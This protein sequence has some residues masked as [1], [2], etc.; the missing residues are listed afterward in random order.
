MTN[1]DRPRIAPTLTPPVATDPVDVLLAPEPR[2]PPGPPA[3][4]AKRRRFRPLRWLFVLFLIAM[5]AP[6]AIVLP[7]RWYPPPTSAFMLRSEVQPV[8]YEWVDASR[9]PETLRLAAIGAEDQKFWDHFGFDLVAIAEAL[10]HNEKNKRK[11]GAS[12]ITQQVAKNLFMWPSRSYLRKGLEA[13]FTLLIELCWPKERILE[14]YLNIAEFGPGVYGAQAAAREFFDK[15]AAD[16]TPVESARLVAVLP[17]PRKW[18]AKH[19][20]P[21]VQARVDWILAHIGYGPPAEPEQA[22][23]LEPETGPELILEPAIEGEAPVEAPADQPAPPP[24]TEAPADDA[25]PAA[26]TAEPP[27]A[28]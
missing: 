12:T 4:P 13:T 15:D 5:L 11:R 23:E 25:A 21:Y 2:E 22:L 1:R 20:G 10:E 3:P 27:P 18:S 8:K 7:L 16:L 9:I 28:P 26:D 19:P 14:V 6:P 17:N 24:E